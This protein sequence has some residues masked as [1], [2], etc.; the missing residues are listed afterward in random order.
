MYCEDNGRPNV[1]VSMLVSVLILKEMFD[2]TDVEV[3]DRVEWSLEWH[4]ALGLMTE[5]AHLNQ[6]TLHNFRSRLMKHDLARVA[7]EETTEKILE[8]L[9]TKV[10]Q[11]RLDSTHIVSNV[12]HLTRL[13]LFV[14]TIRKFLRFVRRE[15]PRLY[16]QIAAGLRGRYLHDDGTNTGYGDGRSGETRRRLPVCARD[17]Y[18]LLA[19]FEKKA[20]G[21]SEEYG[22]LKRLFDEQC[23]I[24]PSGDRSDDDDDADDRHAPVRTKAPA[25]VESSSLQTPHDPDVTYSGHKG[26]GYEVQIAETCNADNETQILTHVAVTPSCESDARA[27]IPTLESLSVRGLHPD[28]LF[29]DTAYGSGGNAVDAE[30]VGIRLVSPVGGAPPTNPTAAPDA[31][32]TAADF[33]IDLTNQR[34]ARCPGGA[35]AVDAIVSDRNRNR[36]DFHFDPDRCRSCP[37]YMQCPAKHRAVH[38]AYV[39]SIDLNARN[40]EQRRREQ[41]KPEFAKH[42]AK[43]AAIEGSNSE[44]KRK[45]GLGRPRVRGQARV[46]LATY[47]KATACNVKRMIQ[48]L[49]KPSETPALLPA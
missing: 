32:K 39:I 5:E 46:S 6:K 26:K 18:R 49:L 22:L 28:E 43:R 3:V 24:E 17:L 13:R 11:Q 31:M 36:I 4:H 1:S 10:N 12:A 14:E 30:R 42:Y 29:A 2:L 16:G 35:E 40:L 34:P 33:D 45:H 7:F 47:F 20:P 23:E 37:L 27:T 21:N 44:C 15:H 25:D 9:G 8:R 48:V 41:A 19:I 38:D